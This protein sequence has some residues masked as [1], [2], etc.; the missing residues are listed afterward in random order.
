[1]AKYKYGARSQ[2][3]LAEVHPD[4][5]KVMNLAITMTDIDFG[6]LDGL[7]T[8]AEQAKN[9]ATG[10][11]RTKNSRH[12]TGHAIDYG[13]YVGGAYI[14]G[15]TAAECKLYAMVAVT[16]KK[17]AEQLKIPITWGGDWRTFKD[18]GHIELPRKQY[19]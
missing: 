15:D 5:Q 13:V 10:A 8:P 4:L 2:K 16:I 6:I 14:N 12:L 3:N 11:S 17:A 9:L 19:P 1:M 7:R 18:M